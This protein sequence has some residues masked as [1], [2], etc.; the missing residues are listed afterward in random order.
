MIKVKYFRLIKNINDRSYDNLMYYDLL[1]TL[2]GGCTTSTIII[3]NI[4]F[5]KC[6]YQTMT[7]L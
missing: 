1:Q 5:I 7:A 3:Q 2:S 4:S 6:N